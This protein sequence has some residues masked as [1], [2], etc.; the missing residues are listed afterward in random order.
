MP[1]PKNPLSKSEAVR[2]A[3]KIIG[4]PRG[5]VP[6]AIQKMIRNREFYRTVSAL[7]DLL[8]DHPQYK[9]I[10]AQALEKIGLWKA[11]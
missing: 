2:L 3:N 10:A 8:I 1:V 9:H 7:D 11:G 5:E 4:I 6:G